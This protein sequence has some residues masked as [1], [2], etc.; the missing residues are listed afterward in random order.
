MNITFEE[1]VEQLEEGLEIKLLC[2]GYDYE[3][4][5]ADN[6]VGGD[7][8]NGYISLVLGNRVYESAEYILKQSIDFLSRNG[9]E[10]EIKI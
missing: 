9:K 6:W 2:D 8:M 7:S 4:S 5:K 3:I 1:A 10:V